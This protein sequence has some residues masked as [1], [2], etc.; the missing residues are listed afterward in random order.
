MKVL[1]TGGGGFIGSHLIDSQLAQGH[2]VRS[3]D[4]HADRLAYVADSP[5][6]E[7]VTGDITETEVAEKIM[8]D[9]EVIYHLASAHLD[10]SLSEERYHNVNVDG[11]LNLLKAARAA[12]VK[13]FVHC[14][15]VGVM[16]DIK[17]PPADES[18]PCW[19]TNIYEKTKL[20]GELA[21]LKFSREMDFP[22]I[23][24]RPAW[25]YGPRCPRTQKL[26]RMIG[27]G[28]FPIFGN[29]RNLRHPVYVADCVR[30][31]EL[32]AKGSGNS[33][34]IYIIAGSVPVTIE[35]LTSAIAQVINV[36]PPKLHIPIALGKLAGTVLQLAYKPLG[37][38]PPFS[39]R[40]LDFFRKNNAYDISKASQ[41][42][43]Y[44]PQ[45]DLRQGLEKTLKEQ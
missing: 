43:G 42:L 28:R 33:G 12:D 5:K 29:G 25:V 2:Y 18:Y 31:L 23:V 1:V 17:N 34:H 35:E 16:G 41:E 37:R 3:V 20:A 4:L 9:V 26:L 45:F 19:P 11:T 10:I 38:Q 8:Q 36:P 21:A 32:C 44:E 15:S 14:S 13:R 40:S 24:A 27:K 30:G 22:V 39:Q 6:L 7:I